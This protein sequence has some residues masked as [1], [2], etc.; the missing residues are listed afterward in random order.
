M[1]SDLWSDLWSALVAVTDCGDVRCESVLSSKESVN[2][3][4]QSV[5]ETVCIN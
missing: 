4:L 1:R 2:G 3:Y 5:L